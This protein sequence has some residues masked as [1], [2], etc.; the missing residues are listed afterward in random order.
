MNDTLSTFTNNSIRLCNPPHPC[1]VGQSEVFNQNNEHP[2]PS[3]I[4][5]L[6]HIELNKYALILSPHL[7]E[8]FYHASE[9]EGPKFG[10]MVNR[11]LYE[12]DNTSILRW[13]NNKHY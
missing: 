11:F 1:I 3:C 6:K 12:M 2:T 7:K 10:K 5:K 9:V 4:L 8:N 13:V